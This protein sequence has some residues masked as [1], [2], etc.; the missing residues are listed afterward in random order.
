[1]IRGYL[2]FYGPPATPAHVASFLDAPVRDV[3]AHWPIDAEEIEV[4]GEK[5]WI[6]EQ[7]RED[8]F[9]SPPPIRVRACSGLSIRMYSSRIGRPWFPIDRPE[10]G[11]AAP[12]RATGH[13]G[14][15][16]HDHRIVATTSIRKEAEGRDHPPVGNVVTIGPRSNGPAGRNTCRISRRRA[17]RTGRSILIEPVASG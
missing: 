14:G 12:P 8:L 16:W 15:R 4:N 2:R 13:G 6:L 11:V 17:L 1:M 3:K 10:D 7:D 5:R 9:G